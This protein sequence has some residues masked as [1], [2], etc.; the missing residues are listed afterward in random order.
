LK[1]DHHKELHKINEEI[2]LLQS[3]TAGK[4]EHMDKLQKQI[5]SMEE[6]TDG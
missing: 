6:H 1:E 5:Q 4:H 2:K 3:E